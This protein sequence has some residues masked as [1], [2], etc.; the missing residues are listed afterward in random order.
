ML[1]PIVYACGP[2]ALSAITEAPGGAA[3]V[4]KC[5]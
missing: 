4:S 2:A 5:H 1:F 3:N